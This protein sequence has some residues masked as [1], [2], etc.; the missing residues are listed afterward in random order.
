[1]GSEIF[2][3]SII[4]VILTLVGLSTGFLLIKLQA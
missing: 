4:I 3:T 2:N 1:M